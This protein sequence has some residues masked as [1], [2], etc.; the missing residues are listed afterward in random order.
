MPLLLG[1]GLPFDIAD[2]R[3]ITETTGADPAPWFRCPFG[4]RSDDPQVLEAL[5][6]AG[7]R[8]VHWHVELETGSRGARARS[9]RTASGATAHGDGA[10]VLLTPGPAGPG[11]RSRP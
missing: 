8:N 7:Y 11:T 9:R 6:T 10:V 1:G 3:A 2:G 4:A 5:E